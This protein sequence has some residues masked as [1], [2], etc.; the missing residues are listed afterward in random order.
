MLQP[1][2]FYS[3]YLLVIVL[4][5]IMFTALVV[6]VENTSNV[7]LVPLTKQAGR[8]GDW[9]AVKCFTCCNL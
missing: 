9:L 4:Y 2:S 1:E 7:H 8:Q 5:C 3:C 6:V